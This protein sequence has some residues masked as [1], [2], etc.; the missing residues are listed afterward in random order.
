MKFTWERFRDG[1]NWVDE[2]LDGVMATEG[3]WHCL[4]WF[5][6]SIGLGMIQLSRIRLE[7]GCIDSD[8]LYDIHINS[9]LNRKISSVNRKI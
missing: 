7:G 5:E 3:I 2:K 8:T 1:P 9:V 4:S 6:I